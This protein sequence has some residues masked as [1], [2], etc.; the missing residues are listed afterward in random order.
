LSPNDI[1]RKT[2]VNETAWLCEG[3]D[4]A[5]GCLNSSPDHVK[6]HWIYLFLPQPLVL[7]A[8]AHTCLAIAA[9]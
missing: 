2:K 9:D 3:W 1:G 4:N 8:F 5:K 6:E 7:H